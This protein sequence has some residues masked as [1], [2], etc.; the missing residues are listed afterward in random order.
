MVHRRGQVKP[1]AARSGFLFFFLP[2]FLFFTIFSVLLISPIA[3]YPAKRVCVSA[4]VRVPI[5]QRPNGF[6]SLSSVVRYPPYRS[7]GDQP[8][9]HAY[10]CSLC[11]RNNKHLSASPRLALISITL[12][13]NRYNI[14]AVVQY[15][16][17]CYILI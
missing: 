15:T 4:C 13:S 6:F 3:K 10:P 12:S 8:L 2:Q 7:K 1:R 16:L 17:G 9:V 14:N 5:S 11:A